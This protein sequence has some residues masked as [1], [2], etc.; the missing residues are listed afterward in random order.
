MTDDTEAGQKA[1]Q[2]SGFDPEA[3]VRPLSVDGLLLLGAVGLLKLHRR[4]VRD[5]EHLPRSSE[6]W[7]YWAMTAVIL[8]RLTS[9]AVPA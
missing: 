8:R 4:L 2:K 7:V 5:Y 1:S 3:W 9:A 6:S